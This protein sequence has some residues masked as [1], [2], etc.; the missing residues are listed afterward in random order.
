MRIAIIGAGRM[1]SWLARET[2][3]DN[4][5]AVIDK[6]KDRAS[7]INGIE[8]L[9]GFKDLAVFDPE[10]LI[11]A[12]TLKETVSAFEAV[13]SYLGPNCVIADVASIKGDLPEYYKRSGFKFVSVHPMFGPTFATMESLNKENAIIIKESDCWGAEFFESFFRRLDVKIHHYTFAD[14]DQMMAYSLTTPFVASLVFGACVDKTAVPGT[15]FARHMKLVK[16]LLSEDDQLLAEVLFNAHSLSQ[17]EK[18]TARLEFLKHVIR[19]RDQEEAER[20]FR[21]LRENVG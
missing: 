6:N 17:I 7:A 16:G 3:T 4:H 14:H 19:G 15:T 13:A 10:L 21:R 2:S 11:N 18:I 20:F 1:G 5:V 9:S 8:S 12:V